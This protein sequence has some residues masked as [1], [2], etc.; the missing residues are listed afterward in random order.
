MADI[1]KSLPN[2]KR[3]EEEVAEE[4]DVAEIEETSKGP[5]EVT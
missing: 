2:V 1:D 4:F 5:V 3:P